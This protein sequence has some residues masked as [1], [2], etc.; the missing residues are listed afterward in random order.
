MPVAKK[1]LR[2][3]K[4]YLAFVGHRVSGLL[5]ALF[6]PIHFLVLGLA[7]DGAESMDRALVFAELPLVKAAE[8]VLVVLL[9]LHFLF[10][11]RI[12]MLELS[13]WPNSTDNFTGWILPCSVAAF[14][15]GVVFLLQV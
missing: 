15:V 9:S 13:E 3:H 10:G 5:L 6:L 8:W 14:F 4:S 11:M 7:L 1:S 12:L 2:I